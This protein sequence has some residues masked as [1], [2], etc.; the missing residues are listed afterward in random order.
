MYLSALN[1][2]A[3][4]P[5]II[6]CFFCAAALLFACKSTSKTRSSEPAAEEHPTGGI[7]PMKPSNYTK[8]EGSWELNY[9]SGPRIAFEGLYPDRKPVITF[10]LANKLVS[11]NNSC[12][13]F[14]GPLN[15]DD[16]KISF[17]EPMAVTKM[18]C[19]GD[20]E[21]VFMETLKTVTSYDV[22]DGQTLNFI[23]GDIAVMRFTKK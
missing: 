2:Y 5:T 7:K 21:R 13:S 22:S 10:D 6:F 3:M 12:N 17:N 20:G 11:G 14:N 9:I 4:R 8:L 15:A 18:L 23:A 19:P 1:V 16:V